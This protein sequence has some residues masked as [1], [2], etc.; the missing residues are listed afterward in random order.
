MARDRA[1]RGGDRG[2]GLRARAEAPD[3]PRVR[4]RAGA[5]DRAARRAGELEASRLRRGLA[6]A[7]RWAPG[8]GRRAPSLAAARAPLDGRRETARRGRDHAPLRPRGRS[9]AVSSPLPTSCAA[10]ERGRGHATSSRAT[11]T[12]PTSATS[13]AAS[14]PSRR[15]SW[16]RTCAA[17]PTSCRST[18]SSAAAARPGSAAQ[19]RSASR[20]GSTRLHG[21]LLRRIVEAIKDARPELHV[22]AFS[23]ARGLAGRRDARPPAR[24]LPR[25]PA[26]RRAWLAARDSRR[27]PRRRGAARSSARTRS[28]T[29]QWLRCIETAHEA[30]LRSNSDDHV[31]LRRGAAELGAASLAI[32]ELQRKRAASPSSCRFRSCTW[33]R[34]SG[35]RARARRGPTFREAVLMHAV[36][37]LAL[38]PHITNIQTSWVKMGREGGAGAARSRSQRSRRHADER[39][40][41]T[42]GRCSARAGDAARGDGGADPRA[43]PHTEAANDAL[44]HSAGG[45]RRLSFGAPPLAE[46]ST[47]T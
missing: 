11:S 35:S 10:D 30:G 18:R 43:R 41:L 38:H 42:R 12:T 44:R 24:R 19:P 13:A 34:R 39:V 32:R 27:D 23:R 46:P 47:R 25:A 17:R 37:R 21:R 1:A 45:A 28:T 29:A 9:G 14:A 3:L 16:R 31:R 40:D 15:A 36:A 6:R 5:L 2:G 4:R 22:H 33:R 26:R 7:D 8:E 20:A